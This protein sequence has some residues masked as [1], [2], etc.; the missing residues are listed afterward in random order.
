MKARTKLQIEIEQRGLN[1]SRWNCLD[2]KMEAYAKQK[3]IERIGFATKK[4]VVCMMCGEGFS[5][6]IVKRKRATCPHCSSRIRIEQSRK[7][8]DRQGFYTAFAQVVDGY[9]VIR[10]F[11]NHCY[12]CAGMKANINTREVLQLW[13]RGDSKHEFYGKSHY[14]NAY[15]DTWG[16][17]ME[18]RKERGYLTKYDLYCEYYHLDST[19]KWE[20]SMYGINNNLA[21][22]TFLE[23]IRN[24]P[25]SPRLETLLKAKQYALLSIFQDRNI[26]RYWP[27]IK[28]CLRNKY[29]VK[30]A[31]T[32]VDYINLLNY[33]GK[34]IHNA[35]Y[36]CPR[37]LHKE[38]DRL[39]R[40]K[41][42]MQRKSEIEAKR[43]RTAEYEKKFAKLKSHL[44]GIK[45]Q[46]NELLVKTLDSVQEYL[47][48]GDKL[49]HCI[50]TNEYFLK[51]DT[52]CLSARINDEPIETVE[53]SLK[54]CK[55]V[56]C[57]G[58][59]NEQSDHHEKILSLI[60]RNM[61]VI[62]ERAKSNRINP[63]VS[64]QQ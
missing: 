41:R 28:I 47:E 18:I 9:Q 57:Q 5:S 2:D 32:W 53:V 11:V 48:E 51:T 22:L 19:F 20:Y 43:R 30:D 60:K 1:L 8:T 54:G 33:F 25:H 23:A 24:V 6:E 37:N 34:D 38:H 10:Y 40:K 17:D 35:H 50:Y 46:D 7:T 56:Q 58:K 27:S 3:V 13:V 59:Y 12:F 14:V 42:E 44:T 55:V 15:C 49:K 63:E 62:A 61:P 31:G 4:R 16:G 36:V 45:F 52:L 39:M 64:L 21:G 29:K 26:D